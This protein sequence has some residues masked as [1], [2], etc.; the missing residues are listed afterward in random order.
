LGQKP[1]SFLQGKDTDLD[2]VAYMKEQI[3]KKEPFICE[4]LNYKKSGESYWLRI[5]GQPIFDKNGNVTQFLQ[6]K[7]ILHPKKQPKKKYR[8]LQAACLL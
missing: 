8:Q 4:I 2:T 5:N 6:L 1:G 7:K 3:R